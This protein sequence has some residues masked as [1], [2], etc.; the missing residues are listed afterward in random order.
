MTDIV[1]HN[2]KYI[3]HSNVSRK[4]YKIIY[5]FNI[6]MFFSNALVSFLRYWCISSTC[7]LRRLDD[8]TWNSRRSRIVWK[9]HASMFRVKRVHWRKKNPLAFHVRPKQKTNSTRLSILR[10][11]LCR[12][13]ELVCLWWDTSHSYMCLPL[14]ASTPTSPTAKCLPRRRANNK[15]EEIITHPWGVNYRY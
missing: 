12:S 5:V 3:P 6:I 9:H 10:R 15:Y 7:T 11:V 8:F 14:K 1:H 4:Q 13:E 2:T